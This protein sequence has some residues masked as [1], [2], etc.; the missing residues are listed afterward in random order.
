MENKRAK[1]PTKTEINDILIRG[2]EELRKTLA[3]QLFEANKSL[4]QGNLKSAKSW[5]KAF[6]DLFDL[7]LKLWEKLKK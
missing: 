7:Y 2:M 4:G 1:L 3:L 6:C 5:L